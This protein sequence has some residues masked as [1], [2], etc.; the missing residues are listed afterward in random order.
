MF[1]ND[2][3]QPW[4]D[5]KAASARTRFHARQARMARVRGRADGGSEAGQGLS[6]DADVMQRTIT[7]A[8]RRVAA[9]RA[10]SDAKEPQS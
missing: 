9:R 8:L 5:R 4:M 7:A 10:G 6:S 3:W 2:G 1:E